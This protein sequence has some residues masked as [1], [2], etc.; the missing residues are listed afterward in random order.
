M[1]KALIARPASAFVK[2]PN[3]PKV[4]SNC[5]AGR[6]DIA[7]TM[8]NKLYGIERELKDVSDEQRFMGSQ[9]KSL[10]ILEQLKSWLNKRSRR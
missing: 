5:K 8:I 9:E 10:P 3:P 6:A 4:Q 1:S 2:T 7:L